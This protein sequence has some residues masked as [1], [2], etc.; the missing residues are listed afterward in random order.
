MVVW[1]VFHVRFSYLWIII[2]IDNL[3]GDW[4]DLC[5]RTSSRATHLSWRRSVCRVHIEKVLLCLSTP[6]KRKLRDEQGE[7][8]WPRSALCVVA[9]VQ[10]RA[11]LSRYLDLVGWSSINK[12]PVTQN[13]ESRRKTWHGVHREGCG[14]WHAAQRREMGEITRGSEGAG[15]R[16]HER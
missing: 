1:I 11:W 16:L 12:R 5:A 9:R 15:R 8:S 10:F 13:V 6:S 2:F 14:V 4:L 7:Q 3:K